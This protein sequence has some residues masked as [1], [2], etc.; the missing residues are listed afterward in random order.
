MPLILVADDD[1]LLRT[2]LQHKLGQAGFE[3]LVASDGREALDMMRERRP[4]VVVLDG[5]MPVIDGFEALRR[6]KSDEAL[7]DIT[8]VMLTALKRE[9]DVVN[10]LKLGAA[11]YLQKPFNPDE[12]VA[13]LRRLAPLGNAA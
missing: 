7:K 2:I 5:M 11:D 4:D 12:L 13:R 9:A 8:V 10:G 3:V 6:I 1:R